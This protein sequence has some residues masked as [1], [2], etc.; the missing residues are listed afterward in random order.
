MDALGRHG[1][2][3][4]A[5]KFLTLINFPG[6]VLLFIALLTEQVSVVVCALSVIYHCASS[7]T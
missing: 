7:L 6:Q 1:I 4:T 2:T 3:L 5:L